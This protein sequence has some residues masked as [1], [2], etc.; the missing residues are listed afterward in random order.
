MFVIAGNAPQAEFS[1]EA[2]AELVAKGY[3][4]ESGKLLDK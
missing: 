4:S 1:P 2:Q 3:I